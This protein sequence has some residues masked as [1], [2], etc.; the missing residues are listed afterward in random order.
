MVVCRKE[1]F[2]QAGCTRLNRFAV[3]HV[4]TICKLHVCFNVIAIANITPQRMENFSEDVA[5]QSQ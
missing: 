3:P 1:H 5:L 2:E 4:V